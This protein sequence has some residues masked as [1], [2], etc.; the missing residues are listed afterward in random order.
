MKKLLLTLLLLFSVGMVAKAQGSADLSTI[1]GGKNATNYNTYKTTNGWTATNSAVNDANIDPSAA[2]PV[3]NGKKTA[4]GTLTSPTLNG[5][6]GEV[7][8]KCVYPYG[9]SNGMKFTLN[10]KQNDAVVKTQTFTSA[11]NTTAEFTSEAFNIAGDFV[12]E[13][14]AG[15]P[16]N[17]TKNKDRLGIY[18]LTWTGYTAGGN[19]KIT[20]DAANI[21][22]TAGEEAIESEKELDANTAVTF[23]YTTD[24]T[25]AD[26][27][28]SYSVDGGEDVE[29]NSYTFTGEKDVELTV[30][31]TS[32]NTVSKTVKL[33]K[34]YPTVCP[35]PVFNV[36]DGA[37]VYAGQAVTVSCEGA[38][39]E[40]TVNDATIT[41]TSYTI[42]EEVGTQLTFYALASIEGR[43]PSTGIIETLMAEK[44][45][46][47][48]VDE[49]TEATFNFNEK[50]YG[51]TRFTAG[52]D[53][54]PT[55]TEISEGIVKINFTGNFRLWGATAGDQLRVMSGATFTI[56]VPEDY[57]IESI[58]FD[59]STSKATPDNGSLSSGNWNYN[60]FASAVKF[61]CGGRVDIDKATIKY[62]KVPPTLD[63]EPSVNIKHGSVGG[64][65]TVDY[66]FTVA[67]YDANK[68][69]FNVT[70]SVDG[71]NDIVF[72]DVTPAVNAAPARAN[73]ESTV[74]HKVMTAKH[75]SLK[76]A[77]PQVSVVATLNGAEVHNKTYGADKI[78][79]TGIED[80]TVEGSAE[81][82]YYNL[83]GLRVAQPEAGQLYIKRQGGKAVKVR[84]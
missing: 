34:K 82:E 62:A 17:S 73:A 31:A 36:E 37:K 32:E 21:V 4:V 66:T 63:G 14:K 23:S 35:E 57:Y 27:T 54:E 25:N 12:I 58:T 74:F 10:I 18:E 16:S 24:N 70:L 9:E 42:T 52:S 8:I 69:S 51:L 59:G 29:G 84:F 72:E 30:K 20:L 40:W 53:Y 64:V 60:G 56:S 55:L 80:V 26:I 41:G 1:N 44:E 75:E 76:G 38:D 13:I 5:G 7:A 78:H 48:T 61:T 79:T 43:N 49:A 81:A 47:V 39:I 11:S 67:H 2:Y 65:L 77:T 19:E 22:V 68:H 46:T 83:Q 6:V 45:I 3:L 71:N 50:N 33:L 15:S 28:Y